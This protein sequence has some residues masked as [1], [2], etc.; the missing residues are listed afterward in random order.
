MKSKLLAVAITILLALAMVTTVLAEYSSV[1]G[2]VH[3][4]K[5]GELWQYGG[6]IYVYNCAEPTALITDTFTNG[7]FDIGT[8]D[9]SAASRLC[10]DIFF[11]GGSEGTPDPKY[12]YR[13]NDGDGE[14]NLGIIYTDTGPNAVTFTALSASS[15]AWLPA[16]IV[17]GVSV[18]VLGTLIVLRK[19]R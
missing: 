8:F 9:S 10:I 3:D 11:N 17:A 14:L 13:P 12:L 19:R 18:L 16:G 15:N 1:T 6:E 7:T 2:E 4:S 5:T